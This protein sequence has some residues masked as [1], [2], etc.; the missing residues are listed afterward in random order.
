MLGSD[1][2]LDWSLTKEGLTIN[3]PDTKPPSEH[4]YVFKIIRNY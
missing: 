2:E 4:A 3:S 1:Q